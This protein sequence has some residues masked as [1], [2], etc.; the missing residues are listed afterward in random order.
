MLKRFEEFAYSERV[1]HAG[2]WPHHA[3]VA[4]KLAAAG[5]LTTVAMLPTS[6]HVALGVLV[7]HTVAEE[8]IKGRALL[9]FLPGLVLAIVLPQHVTVLLCAMALTASVVH[10]DDASPPRYT[11][12]TPPPKAPLKEVVVVS[13]TPPSDDTEPPQVRL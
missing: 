4:A 9:P 2:T 13:A 1:I 10:R 12:P 11:V 7:L 3:G 5:A 8:A 6:T